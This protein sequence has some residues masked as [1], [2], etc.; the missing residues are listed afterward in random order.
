MTELVLN[1]FY[2]IEGQEALYIA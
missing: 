1:K 2:E